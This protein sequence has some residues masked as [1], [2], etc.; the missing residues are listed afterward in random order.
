VRSTTVETS[1]K[2]AVT[3][4]V[5][6]K[7]YLN[8]IKKVKGAVSAFEFEEDGLYRLGGNKQRRMNVLEARA[9]AEDYFGDEV[10][11]DWDDE[12]KEQPGNHFMR[13]E[14]VSQ[15]VIISI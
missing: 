11:V 12:L 9:V 10:E 7:E 2:E 6:N 15:N 8:R 3:D 4:S 1:R 14:Y 5:Y 13:E